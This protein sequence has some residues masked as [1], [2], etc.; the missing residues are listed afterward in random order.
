MNKYLKI[1]LL[2]TIPL[3]LLYGLGVM[4]DKGRRKIKLEYTAVNDIFNG[5]INTD[6]IITGSSRAAVHVSPA[7]LDTLLKISTYN[8][9]MSGWS[10]HMQYSMFR[11][12]LKYNKKPKFIIQNVDELMFRDRENFYNYELFLP[13]TDD[14]IIREATKHYKG[15]FTFAELYFPLF[16]YNNKM[17]RALKGLR[18]FLF[19]VKEKPT[20][21]YKGFWYN[22]MPW[23]K[24]FD[25]YKRKNPKKYNSPI[26]ISLVKEFS[27]FMQYCSQNDIKV[28]LVWAPVYNERYNLVN[29]INEFKK[30]YS[31]FALKYN[32][33][34][35]DYSQDTIGLNTKYFYD[36]YHM[37][38][39]GVELYNYKLA[40]DVKDFITK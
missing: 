9:G 16:K 5:K 20:K 7:I 23:G 27:V 6:L 14:K 13:Y 4:V 24:T 26:D 11:V 39:Y 25:E 19:D 15:A 30:I 21:T 35:L 33:P 1:L 38:K 31:E 28:I 37:N 18:Y 34:F 29:N 12:Y 40:N 3:V 10:F 36:S 17:N 2:I 22:E 32:F 8:I